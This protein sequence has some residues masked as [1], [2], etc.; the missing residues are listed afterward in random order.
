MSADRTAIL[1]LRIK[2]QLT[3]HLRSVFPCLCATVTGL[4]GLDAIH[5]GPGEA[6]IPSWQEPTGT[7]AWAVVRVDG[8]GETMCDLDSGRT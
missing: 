8:A 6:S 7:V 3:C 4:L 5:Q 1:K 2:P